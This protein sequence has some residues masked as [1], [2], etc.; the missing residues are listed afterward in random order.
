MKIAAVSLQLEKDTF[1]VVYPCGKTDGTGLSFTETNDGIGLYRAEKETDGFFDYVDEE[2]SRF[3]KLRLKETVRYVCRIDAPCWETKQRVYPLLP[4]ENSQMFKVE[5]DNDRIVFQFIG[6]LGKSELRF[7]ESGICLPFE[8]VPDKFDYEADYVRLTEALAQQCSLLLMNAVSPVSLNYSATDKEQTHLIEQFIFLK[9]VCSPQNLDNCYLSVKRNPDRH[10]VKET[11]IRPIGTGLPSQR[12]FTNPFSYSRG[13]QKVRQN[14][15]L[16]QEAAVT[17]KYDSYD[18]AANRFLRFALE[19]FLVLTEKVLDRLKESLESEYYLDA[20]KIKE[21]TETFL[22]DSLFD[23]VGIMS[24]LPVNNQILEKREGYY[25]IFKA[26]SMMTLALKLDWDGKDDIYRGKAKN[27]ALLYEYWLFFALNQLLKQIGCETGNDSE[28]SDVPLFIE[29]KGEFRISLKQGKS[30]CQKYSYRHLNVNL[31]YN[32]VFSQQRFSPSSYRGSYSQSFRPDYTIEIWDKHQSRKEAVR[33]GTVSYLHFDAKYRLNNLTELFGAETDEKL[34]EDED[35]FFSR[36]ERDES[37]KTYK[38]GDLFKMHAYNDAIR[39]TVGS[40][41]LY[42]GTEK[43]RY[44][45]YE[46]ILPGVGAFCFRPSDEE[47]NSHELRLFI[48]AVLDEKSANCSREFRK[49]F[50]ENMIIQQPSERKETFPSTENDSLFLLG[51]FKQ[52]YY[53]F[54]KDQNYLSFS[55]ND[56]KEFYFYYYA[57]KNGFVY[58]SHPDIAGVKR[59]C[60]F[61]NT[62]QTEK[63]VEIEPWSAEILSTELVSSEKLRN[64]L[65]DIGYFPESLSAEF[66]FLVRLKNARPF[67]KEEKQII[68]HSLYPGNDLLNAFSP[69]VVSRDMISGL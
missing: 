33:T 49:T 14:R 38:R 58:P 69:K 59:F 39:R 34:N 17:R 62:K 44:S 7:G 67:S 6:Y 43:K 55:H 56:S 26:F 54:L 65:N 27:T 50:F 68:S 36:E 64:L 20:K 42:P 41:I 1:A 4:D 10:L 46:E 16:P 35:R 25:Q 57:V 22:Q 63:D 19:S 12:F 60:C 13:W 66:Y 48:K 32:F 37:V 53:Q 31:Y 15:F 24:V 9:T 30:S 45:D 40:Y 11:E 21:K 61:L 29:E 47:K 8:V 52:N 5:K 28:E 23:D 51:F 2:N 18:T 3:R